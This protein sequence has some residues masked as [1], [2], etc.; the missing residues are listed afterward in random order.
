MPDDVESVALRDI[1]DGDS[2]EDVDEMTMP[3]KII[4]TNKTYFT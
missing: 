2:D 1:E 3:M 4:Q